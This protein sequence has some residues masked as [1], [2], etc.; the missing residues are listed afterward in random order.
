MKVTGDFFN[1]HALPQCL[2]IFQACMQNRYNSTIVCSYLPPIFSIS[3]VCAC[4]KYDF[5]Y[6]YIGYHFK[7][8]FFRLIFI[9]LF[10][11]NFI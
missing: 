6:L 1:K 10:N 2:L 5:M 9:L 7:A 11:V 3:L 8:V 4:F